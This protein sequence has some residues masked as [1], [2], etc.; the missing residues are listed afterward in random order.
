MYTS[1]SI[2][3]TSFSTRVA[4]ISSWENIQQVLE[5]IDPAYTINQLLFVT[6]CTLFEVLSM[7]N[8]MKLRI[9]LQYPMLVEQGDQIE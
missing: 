9:G 5:N 8:G 2:F 3:G 7:I 6:T 4:V 1:L